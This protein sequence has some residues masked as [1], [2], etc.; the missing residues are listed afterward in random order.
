VERQ[1]RAGEGLV[2]RPDVVKSWFLSADRSEERAEG[3]ASAGH[4][5]Q[6]VIMS[7]QD[8]DFR[9]R[10]VPKVAFSALL[11]M[12]HVNSMLGKATPPEAAPRA[13]AR[14]PAKRALAQPAVVT[15]RFV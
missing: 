10:G 3:I 12:A 6:E 4:G 14:A 2:E 7:A 13:S 5:A 11:S 15:V 1:P 9:E 8:E